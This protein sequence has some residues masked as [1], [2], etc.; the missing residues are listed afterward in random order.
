MQRRYMHAGSLGTAAI[1][2]TGVLLLL[3]VPSLILRE[4]SAGFGVGGL[5]YS[6]FWVRA[7]ARAS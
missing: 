5:G 3:Y 4:I 2:F 1:A 6:V 7:A